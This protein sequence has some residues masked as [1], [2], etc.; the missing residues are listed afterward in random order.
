MIDNLGHHARKGAH[1]ICKWAKV[2]GSRGLASP[3]PERI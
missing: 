3:N 2:I 1:V